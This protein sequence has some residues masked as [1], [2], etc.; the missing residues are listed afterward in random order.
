[1]ERRLAL[2]GNSMNLFDT[3]M[4]VLIQVTGSGSEGRDLSPLLVY[5]QQLLGSRARIRSFRGLVETVAQGI[6]VAIRS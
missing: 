1:M 4:E 5:S 2:V 6:S 3:D